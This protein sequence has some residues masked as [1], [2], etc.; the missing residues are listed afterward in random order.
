MIINYLF[1]Q[2]LLK[3]VNNDIKEI[4]IWLWDGVCLFFFYI[5]N[6]FL[7]IATE[8]VQNKLRV[9]TN[10]NAVFS[11]SKYV[12]SIYRSGWDFKYHVTHISQKLLT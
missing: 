11:K 6:S 9:Y 10:W 5:L 3:L 8:E 2:T 4:L 7:L 12:W 1:L